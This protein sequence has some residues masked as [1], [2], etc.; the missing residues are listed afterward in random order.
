MAERP[1]LTS[2]ARGLFLIRIPKAL[3]VLTKE[4]LVRALK[5]GKSLRRAEA[6]ERRE[7]ALK[8]HERR[9]KRR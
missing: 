5:R 9:A 1:I 7:M 3:L 2:P 4:K 8:G 6:S